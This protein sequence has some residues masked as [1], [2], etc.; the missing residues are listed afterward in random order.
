MVERIVEI[1]GIGLGVLI[2]TAMLR[3]ETAAM[4]L[5]FYGGIGLAAAGLG[6]LIS[7][8]GARH[9]LSRRQPLLWAKP[10]FEAPQAKLWTALLGFLLFLLGL[11][12]LWAAWTGAFSLNR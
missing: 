3:I 10:L 8:E 1:Y 4:A 9:M 7:P 2:L 11:A 5:P 12:A 6:A